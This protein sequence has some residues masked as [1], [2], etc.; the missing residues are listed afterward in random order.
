M[1]NTAIFGSVFFGLTAA[2]TWGVGDFS[3][4]FAARRAQVLVVM[5]F[6]QLVGI[7]LLV[8]LALA[9]RERT[10]VLPD[11]AWGAAAGLAGLVGLVCL[12]RAMAQGQ[13]G[14]VA[15]VS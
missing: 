13:M 15:P 7:V 8:G 9:T 3:G 1:N 5:L 2:I 10:P 4:G 12:Y 11:L 14:I 6:S